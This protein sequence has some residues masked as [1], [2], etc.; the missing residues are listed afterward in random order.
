MN[1]TTIK[2]KNNPHIENIQKKKSKMKYSQKFGYVTYTNISMHKQLYDAQI[3]Q[4]KHIYNSYEV[5]ESVLN[6]KYI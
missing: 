3:Y 2:W 5:E 1:L 4:Y 6:R